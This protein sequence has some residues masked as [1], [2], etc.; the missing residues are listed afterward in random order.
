MKLTRWK[1]AL[2]ALQELRI[3]IIISHWT[4]PGHFCRVTTFQYRPSSKQGTYHPCTYLRW[5][6][7]FYN[8]R[9]V[10]KQV[11]NVT[12]LHVLHNFLRLPFRFHNS[13]PLGQ[14]WASFSY[15]YSIDPWLA[16]PIS[17]YANC[18]N[19]PVTSKESPNVYK[20]C[21]KM[22]DFDTFTKIA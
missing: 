8:S 7:P 12:M 10:V 15:Y 19:Q 20:S 18:S 5:K 1:F 11:W 22:I 17:D 16:V 13:L 2:F 6:L 3:I 4:I 21:P 14:I 9:P